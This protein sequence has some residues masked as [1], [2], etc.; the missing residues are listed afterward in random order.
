MQAPDKAA[1]MILGKPSDKKDTTSP[2]DKTEGDEKSSEAELS[3]DELDKA[4]AVR[5]ALKS[6]DDET[7]ALALK[8]FVSVCEGY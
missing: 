8:N 2:D 5:E 4:A 1:I 6:G 7:F 3:Q